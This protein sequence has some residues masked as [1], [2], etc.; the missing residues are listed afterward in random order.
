MENKVSTLED[1]LK[2]KETLHELILQIKLDTRKRVG[3]LEE[4]LKTVKT[5]LAAAQENGKNAQE[6]ASLLSQ[7]LAKVK[8]EHAVSLV[9]A[10]K[11]VCA[12]V[13][14]KRRGLYT[15]ARTCC[16][17]PTSFVSLSCVRTFVRRR[18]RSTKMCEGRGGGG[19]GGEMK[20]GYIWELKDGWWPFQWMYVHT[21]CPQT[22]PCLPLPYQ[23]TV[24]CS[25]HMYAL[26]PH[27]MFYMYFYTDTRT[28][29]HARVHTHTHKHT[30]THTHTHKHTHTHTR[31]HSGGDG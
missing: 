4:E 14:R 9:I 23:R 13:L 27:I 25:W 11:Q 2:D 17:H 16:L 7:E 3:E 1:S 8:Q 29:I 24:P 18:K 5:Q 19:R 10:S 26:L 31:T 28:H 15:H 21:H 6:N 22:V 30:H 12:Y 20:R